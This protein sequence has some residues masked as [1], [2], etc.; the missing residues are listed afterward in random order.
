M[1]FSLFQEGYILSVSSYFLLVLFLLTRSILYSWILY[2]RS[3]SEVEWG[4]GIR[5][6]AGIGVNMIKL[7]SLS[8]AFS[9]VNGTYDQDIIII[10][11][12]F[13]AMKGYNP[14]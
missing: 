7:Y 2:S 13:L 14:S 10:A 8:T 4:I 9:V 5:H 3:N 6:H 11:T 12:S 1:A